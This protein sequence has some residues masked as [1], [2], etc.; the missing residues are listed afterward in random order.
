[1]KPTK[2]LILPS[3]CIITIIILGMWVSTQ[4][5]AALLGY[6]PQLGQP[7]T[8]GVI[9]RLPTTFIIWWLKYG[10]YA[11]KQFDLA[12]TTTYIRVLLGCCS[13][14]ATPDQAEKPPTW[15][16]KVG[17]IK[18]I[19]ESG[20]LNNKGVVLGLTQDGQYLR[21]DG[22]AR[23]V[24]APTRSGRCRYHHPYPADVAS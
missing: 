6:P 1:M 18:D 24:M 16:C 12:S 8:M 22:Q 4:W 9:R 3:L 5:V 17:R 7:W 15:I 13:C 10:V 21:H 19:K 2:F 14:M 11:Q 23:L 20:L